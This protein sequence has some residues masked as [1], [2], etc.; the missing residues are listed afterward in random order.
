MA[1]FIQQYLKQKGIIR[2]A[3]KKFEQYM[4]RLDE[5]VRVMESGEQELEK[6]LQLYEEGVKITKICNKMLDE[7]EQKVTILSKSEGKIIESDFKGEE[8]EL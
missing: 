8:D 7:A 6:T 2:M 1:R 5:I 3:E 4:T